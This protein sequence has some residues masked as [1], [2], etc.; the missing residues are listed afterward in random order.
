MLNEKR[1]IMMTRLASYEE[2]EGKKNLSIGNYY[3]GDYLALQI[4]KSIV[5]STICFFIVFG[6]YIL[7]NFETF[8]QDLYKI[9]LI[10]FAQTVLKYYC[11]TVVA[12]AVLTY[13][14]GTIRYVHAKK[15]LQRY[16]KNLKVLK[17]LYQSTEAWGGEE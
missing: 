8:M 16:Y 2:G 15:N 7:Y 3:R 6:M 1:V 17:S 13:V 4:L 10:A 9:D 14:V 11:I 5:C 12:Y